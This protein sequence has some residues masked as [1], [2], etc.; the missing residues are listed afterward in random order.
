MRGDTVSDTVTVTAED[1]EG[2]VVAGSDTA[3]VVI[4]DVQPSIDLDKSASPASVPEPGGD[5]TFTVQ[6]PQR[7]HRGRHAGL[8]RR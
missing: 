4:T 3:E 2:T 8:P 5:V 6:G 7:F 1:N